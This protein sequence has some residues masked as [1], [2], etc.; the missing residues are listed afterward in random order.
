MLGLC[1][2]MCVCGMV[3]ITSIFGDDLSAPPNLKDSLVN[4]DIMLL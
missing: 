2:S 4:N 3:C 1:Q